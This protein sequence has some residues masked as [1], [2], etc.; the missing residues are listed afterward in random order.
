MAH[1]VPRDSNQYEV[2]DV[3]RFMNHVPSFG[4][5]HLGTLVSGAEA[6]CDLPSLLRRISTHLFPH[7]Q[8][9]SEAPQGVLFSTRFQFPDSLDARG[10]STACWWLTKA[11]T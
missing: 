6:L 5:A 10:N 4:Y 8:R 3:V 11:E 7:G 2:Q 1:T 9:Q